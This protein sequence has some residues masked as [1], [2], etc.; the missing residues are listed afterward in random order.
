MERR[1]ETIGDATPAE[2]L[3]TAEEQMDDVLFGKGGVNYDPNGY[4]MKAVWA[5]YEKE[6]KADKG[7]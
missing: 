7:Q 1:F 3:S 4:D 6:E 5:G 2:K